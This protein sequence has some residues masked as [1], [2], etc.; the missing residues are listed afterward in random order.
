MK[1]QKE[2]RKRKKVEDIFFSFS[3]LLSSKPFSF[4]ETKKK[5]SL[6]LLSK[7]SKGGKWKY[8][9]KASTV[10]TVRTYKHV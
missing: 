1:D 6:A 4:Y 8:V 5:M 7:K 10:Y 2:K 3:F 9:L